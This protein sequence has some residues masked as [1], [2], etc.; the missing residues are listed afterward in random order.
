MRLAQLALILLCTA[1]P[2][3]LLAELKDG[4]LPNAG[5]YAH[6]DLTEMRST[7]AGRQLYAWLDQEVF[8]ELRDEY[9]FDAD[10]E[11]DAIT[12]LSA[13][14]GSTIIVVDGDFSQTTRDRVLA[15]S[16]LAGNFNVLKHD[17]RDYY[18]IE[19]DAG[20][21]S[22]GAFEDVAFVSLA[23]TGKLLVTSSET[24]MQRMLDS[25]G[26]LPG[27]HADGDALLILRGSRN[28]V[29]AGMQ[30]QLIDEGFGWDSNLLRNTEQLGFL[31]ADEGGELAVMAQLV[32]TDPTVATSLA[33]I[34][35]GLISLQALSGEL[36]PELSRY[37]NSTEVA[38]DGAT[39]TV[40]IALDPQ[41]LIEAIR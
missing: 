41:V 32:A 39:L 33:S 10:Q 2:G 15:I 27:N 20:E 31:V 26:K 8:Q 40:R 12:A 16:A 37:L 18:Q 3:S 35:R 17:G 6:I 34:V 14:D 4:D 21:H 28:F 11:A 29:Q 24:Q 30:T 25:G 9:D 36:D 1:L 13:T 19:D 38:I 5:W 22:R 23:V 7:D